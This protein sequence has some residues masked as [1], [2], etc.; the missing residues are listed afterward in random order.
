MG[1]QADFVK[2][3]EQSVIPSVLLLLKGKGEQYSPTG[4]ALRNFKEPAKDVMSLQP[5]QYL[6]VLAGKQWFVVNDWSK[7]FTLQGLVKR[8]IMQ[9]I[10][11]IVVYMFL[12]LF[13]IKEDLETSVSSGD[14]K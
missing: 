1:T 9:R 12:L 4:D 3:V 10:L 6:M 5:A 8:E 7:E 13:M 14:V 11:D 2:Y